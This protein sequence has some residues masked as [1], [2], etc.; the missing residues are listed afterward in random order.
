MIIYFIFLWKRNFRKKFEGELFVIYLIG[1]STIRGIVEFSRINPV[2][3]GLFSISHLLSLGLIIIGLI[4]YK[5]ISKKSTEEVDNFLED[6]VKAGTLM[7]SLF[8]LILMS[9]TIFYFVQA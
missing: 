8:A 5:L 3:W 9:L 1:F 4:A 7:F 2:I 6:E